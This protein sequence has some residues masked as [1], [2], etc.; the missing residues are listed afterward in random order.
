MNCKVRTVRPVYV[1]GLVGPA[2]QEVLWV[3][4]AKNYR[5]RNLTRRAPRT[6]SPDGQEAKEAQ[7]LSHGVTTKM[8]SDFGFEV[9]GMY[10]AG[11]ER[12]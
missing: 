5:E 8:L 2:Q 7:P 10:D 4:E 6:E 3:T 9:L 12:T 1:C 11:V